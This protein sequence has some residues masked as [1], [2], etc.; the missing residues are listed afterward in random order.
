MIRSILFVASFCIF[1]SVACSSSDGSSGGGSSS[2]KSIS[3]LDVSPNPCI[4]G[5][6]ASQQMTAKATYA[7]GTSADVTSAVTWS[8]SDDNATITS[9]G[10]LVGTNIGTVTV[11]A[12]LDGVTGTA[13]CGVT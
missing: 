10:N 3:T 9:S 5:H 8:V 13:G 4:V 12:T 11:T 2:N 1:S 6:A 7:D